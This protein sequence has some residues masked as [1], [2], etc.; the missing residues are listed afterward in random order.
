MAR[1][2]LSTIPAD[3]AAKL[4]R[5]IVPKDQ[6]LINGSGPNDYICDHCGTVLISG[7]EPGAVSAKTLVL[8]CNCGTQSVT[9][10]ID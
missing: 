2:P 3:K 5:L 6:P 7:A 8:I 1:K 10:S 4:I 9:V